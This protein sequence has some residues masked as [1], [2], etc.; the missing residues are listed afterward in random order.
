MHR[1]IAF[2]IQHQP[3]CP[4]ARGA[5]EAE[6]TGAEPEDPTLTSAIADREERASFE[7][8]MLPHL[9]AAYNLA[10]WM[11]R[12]EADAQDVVQEAYLRALRFYQGFAG[13]NGR[14]WLLA[15]VRNTCYTWMQRNRPLEQALLFDENAHFPDCVRAN[16]ETE[17]LRRAREESIELCI[18]E[19]P[20]EFREIIVMREL[21]GMSYREI[22]EAA[23]VPM[24]T[25][26][27]RLAR[28]RKR[29]ERLVHRALGKAE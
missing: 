11:T 7:T 6:E 18:R 21:E 29:L 27:S 16:P 28:G 19:L 14:G 22:A 2:P 24:G 17:L 8:A 3:V 20:V 1:S 10:R 5:R 9:D 15:I 12:N 4:P 25:V 23:E 26:M 13:G